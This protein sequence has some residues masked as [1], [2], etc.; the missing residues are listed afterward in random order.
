MVNV[1][2]RGG[3]GVVVEVVGG[4]G[5]LFGKGVLCV[6]YGFECGKDRSAVKI[7]GVCVGTIVAYVVTIGVW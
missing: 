5:A 1:R 6:L 3:G 7:I 4:G 2:D